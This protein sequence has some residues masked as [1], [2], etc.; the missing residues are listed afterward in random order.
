MSISSA[1]RRAS[2]IGA[3]PMPTIAIKHTVR[4][5]QHRR[6]RELRE[7]LHERGAQVVLGRDRRHEL[8]ASA[9]RGDA[10]GRREQSAGAGAIGRARR[11]RGQ[12]EPRCRCGSASS[13]VTTAVV[14]RCGDDRR[15]FARA[16]GRGEPP[17]RGDLG[18]LPR[19]FVVELTREVA[20]A[21][22]R[23]PD[24]R[25]TAAARRQVDDLVAFVMFTSSARSSTDAAFV[26]RGDGF[27][28]RR[29][30]CCAFGQC[31]RRPRS[32]LSR[33]SR[34]SRPCGPCSRR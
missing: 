10:A 11:R 15:V 3:V 31:R 33:R 23:S 29:A 17:A 27:G 12:R 30:A 26:A 25:S 2:A 6:R 20:T 9:E 13:G 34:R 28:A 21:S 19:L 22:R 24:V 4:P 32:L 5:R 1:R 8:G 18:R 7:P 14:R 16:V